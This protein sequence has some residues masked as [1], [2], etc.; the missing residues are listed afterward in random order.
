MRFFSTSN[1]HGPVWLCPAEGPVL[2]AQGSPGPGPHSLQGLWCPGD[3]LALSQICYEVVPWSPKR[4]CCKEFFGNVLSG[5]R[6][7]PPL[8]LAAGQGLLSADAA[9]GDPVLL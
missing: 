1:S 2:R 4:A 5:P 7:H 9:Q 3:I 6:A 8:G